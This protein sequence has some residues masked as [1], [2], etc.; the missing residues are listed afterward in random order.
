LALGSGNNEMWSKAKKFKADNEEIIVWMS[1][2]IV[3]VIL[4]GSPKAGMWYLYSLNIRLG[5]QCLTA[6]TRGKVPFE[7]W[8]QYNPLVCYMSALLCLLQKSLTLQARVQ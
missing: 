5:S 8:G 2:Q 7:L 4:Q 6:Q 3:D 1:F